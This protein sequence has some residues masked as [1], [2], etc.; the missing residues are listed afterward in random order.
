M[1]KYNSIDLGK[2]EYY[3]ILDNKKCEKVVNIQNVTHKENFDASSNNLEILHQ[4]RNE[5]KIIIESKCEDIN[6]QL[7]DLLHI[8]DNKYIVK[9]YN[10]KKEENIVIE[11]KYENTNIQSTDLLQNSDNKHVK[12]SPN[13]LIQVQVPVLVKDSNT[14]KSGRSYKPS[15]L[16]KELLKDLYYSGTPPNKSSMAT[17]YLSNITKFSDTSHNKDDKSIKVAGFDKN[18]LSNNSPTAIGNQ[19]M[20][21]SSFMAEVLA[22]TQL[23]NQTLYSSRKNSNKTPINVPPNNLLPPE[24]TATSDHSN[25]EISQNK[26]PTGNY[27][28]QNVIPFLDDQYYCPYNDQNIVCNF[29]VKRKCHLFRHI[30]HVHRDKIEYLDPDCASDGLFYCKMKECCFMS[31]SSFNVAA[32]LRTLHCRCGRNFEEKKDKKGNELIESTIDLQNLPNSNPQPNILKHDSLFPNKSKINHQAGNHTCDKRHYIKCTPRV[33][34][35]SRRRETVYP[36]ARFPQLNQ[37]NFNE[38]PLNPQFELNN[39]IINSKENSFDCQ[40]FNENYKH[41][42]IFGGLGETSPND[43]D[44]SHE[45]FDKITIGGNM[46]NE[47]ESLDDS[48]FCN[49]SALPLCE[50]DK[51][52]CAWKKENDINIRDETPVIYEVNAA[53]KNGYKAS[54]VHLL[55]TTTSGSSKLNRF[56]LKRSNSLDISTDRYSF[57]GMP[58]N[59]RNIPLSAVPSKEEA[60]AN[61]HKS[62]KRIFAPLIH[63]NSLIGLSQDPTIKD[64]GSPKP[65]VDTADPLSKPD[66]LIYKRGKF[67]FLA[68]DDFHQNNQLCSS[69]ED[70][71]DKDDVKILKPHNEKENDHINIFDIINSANKPPDKK[72]VTFTK[73]EKKSSK[74]KLNGFLTTKDKGIVAQNYPLRLQKEVPTIIDQS[75][76][77]NSDIAVNP[78][79]LKDYSNINNGHPLE[80]RREMIDY[81]CAENFDDIVKRKRNRVYRYSSNG[82]PLGRPRKI[83]R[84]ISELDSDK[85][86]Y[87]SLDETKNLVKP[88]NFIILDAPLNSYATALASTIV[89]IDIAEYKTSHETE[90]MGKPQNFTILDI[91]PNICATALVAL[92]PSPTSKFAKTMNG[93]ITRDRNAYKSDLPSN[94]SE[95]SAIECCLNL[96]LESV[97]DSLSN[98]ERALPQK[99]GLIRTEPLP[100][101]SEESPK[102]LDNHT[103]LHPYL[104]LEIPQDYDLDVH[105]YPLNQI[106]YYQ[107]YDNHAKKSQR[108]PLEPTTFTTNYL[109]AT[110]K[111]YPDDFLQTFHCFK[112]GMTLDLSPPSISNL[113]DGNAKNIE[114][115]TNQIRKQTANL[116]HPSTQ[117]PTPDEFERRQ[118]TPSK[119]ASIV[120]CDLCCQSYHSY[121]FESYYHAFK[122]M[123]LPPENEIEKTSI[124]N[125]YNICRNCQYCWV[126]FKNE[127][128][129][130]VTCHTC[131]KSYHSQCLGPTITQPTATNKNTSQNITDIWEC[132]ICQNKDIKNSKAQNSRDIDTLKQDFTSNIDLV[133][134]SPKLDHNYSA[135][136]QMNGYNLFEYLKPRLSCNFTPDCI[137]NKCWLCNLTDRDF[138]PTDFISYPNMRNHDLNSLVPVSDYNLRTRWLHLGCIM[139]FDLLTFIST[140]AKYRGRKYLFYRSL[141]P[142]IYRV[143]TSICSLC[144]TAGASLV[145]QSMDCFVTFHLPC[146]SKYINYNLHDKNTRIS[147]YFRHGK[148]VV[149][150][151]K[152]TKVM[153]YQH[154]S[155][156][157]IFNVKDNTAPSLFDKTYPSKP[158]KLTDTPNIDVT[159]FADENVVQITKKFGK[160]RFKTDHIKPEMDGR[161]VYFDSCQNS[162]IARSYQLPTRSSSKF[163][164]RPRHLSSSPSLNGKFYYA[165]FTNDIIN[166]PH[167]SEICHDNN[168]NTRVTYFSRVQN[169]SQNYSSER[170]HTKISHSECE[171]E[172]NGLLPVMSAKTSDGVMNESSLIESPR[173]ISRLIIGCLHITNVG[174]SFSPPFHGME[175]QN[176][177]DFDSSLKGQILRELTQ[178]DGE[179]HLLPH[180]IT[181]YP[182]GFR[183]YRKF[184][185]TSDPD[186]ICTYKLE[187]INAA[188]LVNS[189]TRGNSV[190]MTANRDGRGGGLDLNI[191]L[192]LV[193]SMAEDDLLCLDVNEIPVLDDRSR[194]LYLISNDEGLRRASFNLEGTWSEILTTIFNNKASKYPTLSPLPY[195]INC[196]AKLFG[197][198]L[199][200]V[201]HL[202][203]QMDGYPFDSPQSKN[204]AKYILPKY[205]CSRLIPY[206][207]ILK[208]S[209]KNRELKFGIK[210]SSH[211]PVFPSFLPDEF[212]NSNSDLNNVYINNNI[213]SKKCNINSLKTLDRYMYMK[214][215]Y[216]SRVYISRSRIHEKGLFASHDFRRGHIIIEYVGEII[217]NIVADKREAQQNFVT[218]EAHRTPPSQTMPCYLFRLNKDYIIDANSSGNE[219]RYINHSCQPNCYSKIVLCAGRRRILFYASA[220]IA[221]GCEITYDYKFPIEEIEE[222]QSEEGDNHNSRIINNLK[223]VCKCGSKACL[224]FLN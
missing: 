79:R 140:Q 67:I 220:F 40:N 141:L 130:F 124:L 34:Y 70:I 156:S 165:G 185:S 27:D 174:S 212:G 48:I 205:G 219:S 89:D 179:D 129:K 91:S 111:N 15:H 207:R 191:D 108:D 115:R 154:N 134:D 26:A 202:F 16:V 120:F 88:Q 157:P 12:E 68:E 52:I 36:L 5:E 176:I 180:N 136:Q 145:C 13:P 142:N 146:I 75:C 19:N 32:H 152:H 94:P 139:T 160:N 73:V 49:L 63:K 198:R 155:N 47:R 109:N 143:L 187:I 199:P 208:L 209:L 83:P 51:L 206:Q 80:K 105:G 85:A 55:N 172:I 46:D 169:V 147:I 118:R 107:K 99:D 11:T 2:S 57:H 159:V 171:T 214:A 54:K 197:L 42:P 224:G 58:K 192:S 98:N 153:P 222:G 194:Q 161:E 113:S 44:Q 200:I 215:T 183:S 22:S 204:D 114:R 144:R 135:E 23:Q 186:K 211:K 213:W 20:N 25:H 95:R 31:R 126:C 128:F 162:N 45:N 24:E 150:C 125:G 216:R 90:N 82:R 217:R 76:I 37:N 203:T 104:L 223:I 21:V 127:P 100:I 3:N 184:W 148:F 106:Y 30:A 173:K 170:M 151:P 59:Q 77:V 167:Q 38:P 103:N 166:I 168:N 97:C 81:S 133:K 189:E 61:S 41:R 9:N 33:K 193:D 39:V 121:C 56:P 158:G 8:P 14:R 218:N 71:T 6:M 28:I 29:K 132:S 10:T 60:R 62:I 84:I 138:P 117:F 65:L 78:K 163:V 35:V 122:G 149:Y 86:E 110:D 177:N 93:Y 131:Y 18:E 201:L 137:V 53:I 72:D 64:F 210:S 7:N 164:L 69:F 188:F 50:K 102:S 119:K 1:L 87:V 92:I 182:D 74:V 175:C 178:V 195:G 66:N 43:F 181:T 116:L 4:G 123:S 101:I 196:P 112:C 96:M 17:A 221:K 190:Y